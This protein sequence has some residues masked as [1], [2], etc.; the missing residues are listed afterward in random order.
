MS[1]LPLFKGVE[2]TEIGYFDTNNYVSMKIWVEGCGFGGSGAK[3]SDKMSTNLQ[4][5]WDGN[6]IWDHLSPVKR[7]YDQ[8]VNHFGH[9]NSYTS[10]YLFKNFHIF[11]V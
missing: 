7:K 9:T 11:H 10:N 3:E 2:E 6:R 1:F 4:S 5:R 8:T